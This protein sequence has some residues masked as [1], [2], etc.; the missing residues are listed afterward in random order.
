MISRF[1][2]CSFFIL[3]IS[4]VV[5]GQLQ[6]GSWMINGELGLTISTFPDLGGETFSNTTRFFVAPELACM[7]TD[8]LMLGG[9]LSLEI[10]GVEERRIAPVEQNLL[11][12]HYFKQL[13]NLS[14]FYGGEISFSK[15][16]F[17]EIGRDTRIRTT[18]SAFLQSG[19]HFFLQ[20]AIAIEF[21]FNYDVI[22]LRSGLNQFNTL[23][24][25]GSLNLEGRLQF[26]IHPK[27]KTKST[28]TDYRFY[29]GNW[30]IGGS[31]QLGGN[32]FLSPEI[33]RFWGSGWTTG[34]R[35]ETEISLS[36]R[37]GRF[38]CMPLVRKYFR[39]DKKGKIWLQA[40]SGIRGNYRRVRDNGTDDYWWTTASRD[41]FLEGSVG[42]SN[43][44]SP[45]FTLDFFITRLYQKTYRRNDPS[46]ER[47][48]F[49]IGLA[50]NGLLR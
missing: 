16:T 44:I 41:L 29:P 21:L 4:S 47:N 45:N 37:S 2:F 33:Q 19:L 22:S 10:T 5:Q 28:E 46:E 42:W 6:K 13:D 49:S 14:L 38:G 50:V 18:K 40:G 48:T 3:T 15:I 26:F 7:V 31:F 11:I 23:V 9:K 17:S 36:N 24:N 35:F 25:G 8:H 12:R 34:L 1:L 39:P 43:L 20:R 30:L 27:D 32:D